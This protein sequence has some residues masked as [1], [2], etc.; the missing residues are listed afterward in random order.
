MTSPPISECQDIDAVVTTEHAV[1]LIVKVDGDWEAARDALSAEV[2]RRTR[3][4]TTYARGPEFAARYGKRIGVVRV[5][6]P[7]AVPSIVAHLLAEQGIE[8]ENL[9]ITGPED[10]PTCG[11]CGRQR[12]TPEQA[13]VTDS[14]WACPS[15]LRAWNVKVQP[16]LLKKPRQLRIPPRLWLPLIIIVIALF[17]AG[18]YY[19]LGRLNKMNRVIRLHVPQ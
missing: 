11:A 2:E 15:C 3:A 16:D 17:A 13:A 10:G 7:T 14:G 9:S 6:S 4:A 18:V 1:H 5:Q 19:E 12:L 8:V